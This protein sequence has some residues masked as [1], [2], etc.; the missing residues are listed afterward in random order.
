MGVGQNVLKRVQKPPATVQR[1]SIRST[2]IF[3]KWQ[4]VYLITLFSVSILMIPAGAMNPNIRHEMIK[5]I[6]EMLH[7][8]IE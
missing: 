1:T 8:I 4:K 6:E 2:H 3:K 5:V 7:E